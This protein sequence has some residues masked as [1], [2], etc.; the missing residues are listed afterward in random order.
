[1]VY[2]LPNS[3]LSLAELAV[4]DNGDLLL[5]HAD[6]HDRRLMLV[7]P[8]GSLIWEHSIRD[9]PPGGWRLVSHEEA[10][11]LLVSGSDSSGVKVDMY[12]IDLESGTLVHILAGGTRETYTRNTWLSPV[13]GGLFLLNV[14][15]GPLVGFDPQTAFQVI[16]PP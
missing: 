8:E 16:S 14:G 10:V 5:I 2:A 4:L 3:V 15:D 13:D 12:A 6:G 1:M 9:L 11:Y 7:E